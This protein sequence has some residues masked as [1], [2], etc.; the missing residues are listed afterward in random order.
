MLR[1]QDSARIST[2]V[3]PDNVVQPGSDEFKKFIDQRLQEREAEQAGQGQAAQE[4]STQEEDK[5]NKAKQAE[6]GYRIGSDLSVTASFKDGLFL[7]LE[8]PNKDFT[9][10]IG[11]WFQ[12]DN[13][14]WGQS[15]GM[16]TP[17]GTRPGAAQGVASGI[18]SGG[19][20]NEQD[21]GDFRRI[22]PFVERHLLGNRRVP[23]DS[24]TGK[25]SIQHGRSRRILGIH[26]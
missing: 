7:W 11:G 13:T 6:L 25:Q 15:P 5:A 8:T 18:A 22:R 21:G 2:G 9:M 24:R 20:G 26:H 23:A 1:A 4:T 3:H 17:Q 19:V 12:Y 14:F 16:R 10:H